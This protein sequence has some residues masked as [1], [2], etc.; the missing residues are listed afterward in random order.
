MS[1]YF[2]HLCIVIYINK[3]GEFRVSSIH[4]AFFIWLETTTEV[5]TTT[6]D[7]PTTEIP[8]ATEDIDIRGNEEAEPADEG[9]ILHFDNLIFY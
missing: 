4:Y 5:V 8:S 3:K 7:V 2:I 1:R 9:N 6:E